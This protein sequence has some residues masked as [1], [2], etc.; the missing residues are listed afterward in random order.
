MI[1]TSPP[2]S[3]LPPDGHEFPSSFEEV[4][5]HGSKYRSRNGSNWR[6]SRDEKSEKSVKDK[7]A[8]FT[9]EDKKPTKCSSPPSP[10]SPPS[11]TATVVAARLKSRRDAHH[12]GQ[13][14]VGNGDQSPKYVAKALSYS[15]DNLSSSSPS[16]PSSSSAAAAAAVVVVAAGKK[17]STFT[18][19]VEIAAGVN[20]ETT[21]TLA[22][23]QEPKSVNDSALL[24]ERCRSLL[25][26]TSSAK[27]HS[28]GHV[29]LGSPQQRNTS[30]TNL[31]ESRRKSMSK[32]RGLV[33]PDVDLQCD[34]AKNGASK[35]II[36][37][38]EIIS[39]DS[40]LA[41]NSKMASFSLSRTDPLRGSQSSITSSM[42]SVTD[43]ADLK[44]TSLTS[45]PWKSNSPTLPK[46]SPAFKRKELS[47]SRSSYAD[48]NS[49]HQAKPDAM[50]MMMMKS[51]PS[52]R[53]CDMQITAPPVPNSPPPPLTK[54]WPQT[55]IVDQVDG[56]VGTC[57]LTSQQECSDTDAD[58]A[59]SSSRS[60]LS[61]AESPVPQQD[62]K[63]DGKNSSSSGSGSNDHVGRVLKAHSVE[64][65]NRKNVLQSARY[66]SGLVVDYNSPQTELR[67]IQV[68]IGDFS[69]SSSTLTSPKSTTNLLRPWKGADFEH[70]LKIFTADTVKGES[71]PTL[72]KRQS[73]E[74]LEIKMA[75]VN[76]ISGGG[77]GGEDKQAPS[78]ICKPDSAPVTA[79]QTNDTTK[80]MPSPRR[81]SSSSDSRSTS[82]QASPNSSRESKGLRALAER[83]QAI[84]V[85][86][87]ISGPP[88][89]SSS[90][91]SSGAPP[92]AASPL[93][94]S[95]VNAVV[96]EKPV[97]AE[98]VLMAEMNNSDDAVVDN[99][100]EMNDRENQPA[101]AS[102]SSS[103]RSAKNNMDGVEI[104]K[105]F[106]RVKEQL[107]TQSNSHM[108]TIVHDEAAT[109]AVEPY[110]AKPHAI[111]SLPNFSS[112]S[113]GSASYHVRMSSLDSTASEDGSLPFVGFGHFGIG[114]K[115]N[116]GS[117][118][119]LASSTSLISP[120]VKI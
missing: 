120:Q 101:A 40:V 22:R 2:T 58:S 62:A 88:L 66:S 43:G 119:S 55:I 110:F 59:L 116:F 118:T 33:I 19:S 32:L 9:S 105:A 83:W 112:T 25:D 80:S 69:P 29:P 86:V 20:K 51:E 42:C 6:G 92:P 94:R 24:S 99:L 36:D 90:S 3:R 57:T 30:T 77:G 17:S 81:Y 44:K 56:K 13:M 1:S 41:S 14:H 35:A 10:P 109:A 71:P 89:S 27:R 8:L 60:S 113:N 52:A 96:D 48:C 100:L 102:L 11:S 85:D 46:Y 64:A 4:A 79:L 75:Y 87:P 45:L 5:D 78:P 26:V 31:I 76:D 67:P 107:E 47:V 108:Q 50:M 82:S 49:A 74:K 111:F 93:S 21:R 103:S 65:L 34:A 98:R 117:I 39:K 73:L 97:A 104:R 28:L 38:P 23:S 61:P 91:S 15:V 70:T 12:D 54:Q 18:S 7:I 72:K 114:V 95:E 84:A 63:D 53:E 16:S 115:D 106:E 37:L 68:D